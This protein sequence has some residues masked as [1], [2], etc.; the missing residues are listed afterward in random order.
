MPVPDEVLLRI[1]TTAMGLAPDG[2]SQAAVQEAIQVTAL[3]AEGASFRDRFIHRLKNLGENRV[4]EETVREVSES[5]HVITSGKRAAKAWANV[6]LAFLNQCYITHG[7][8]RHLNSSAE[9]T[10]NLTLAIVMRNFAGKG[11]GLHLCVP[12][13]PGCPSLAKL[14]EWFGEACHGIVGTSLH[15]ASSVEHDNGAMWSWLR[16][17]METTLVL[18]IPSF[19][20]GFAKVVIFFTKNLPTFRGCL[21]GLCA[22]HGA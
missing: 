6:S 12:R 11:F 17:A 2:A 14:K 3:H 16:M 8:A 19:D 4:K 22:P 21:T 10:V 13:V 7:N 5:Q 20:F 15:T 18:D 9:S 1:K